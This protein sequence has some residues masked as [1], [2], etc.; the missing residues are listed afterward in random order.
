MSTEKTTMIVASSLGIK[1][2]QEGIK[3]TACKLGR[4][5]VLVPNQPITTSTSFQFIA[6]NLMA[7]GDGSIVVV[8]GVH[9]AVKIPKR[10]QLKALVPVVG[11]KI[12]FWLR[13]ANPRRGYV[14]PRGGT[15][16]K[17][18]GEAEAGIGL[19]PVLYRIQGEASLLKRT[20]RGWIRK[21]FS[22]VRKAVKRIG[23][24]AKAVWGHVRGHRQG[25]WRSGHWRHLSD[26]VAVWVKGCFVRSHYWGELA[27]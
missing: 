11:R 20:V 1:E 3:W 14:G 4:E 17:L 18:A 27:K 25:H 23:V 12:A 6:D 7:L 21:L 19:L 16:D 8:D 22:V 26:D 13:S 24:Y 5:E 10:K 2:V 9:Y 15:Y